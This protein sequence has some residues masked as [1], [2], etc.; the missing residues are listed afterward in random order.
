MR[1]GL[2]IG[3]AFAAAV[4]AGVAHADVSVEKV[5]CLGL[6]GCHRLA[7]GAVEVVVTT[8]VGPRI[9]SYRLTGGENLFWQGSSSGPRNEW[10]SYGG[11]RLWAAP[12]AVPRTYAPDND[13]VAFE[14]EPSGAIRLTAPVEASTGLQKSLRVILDARGPGVTVEH[15]IANRGL[16]PI[17]LAPWALTVFAGGG[18]ALVPQEPP[19]P[20]ADALLPVRAMA[21][22][23]Y[24][25]MTDPR[26]AFGRRYVRVRSLDSVQAPLKIGFG[27][28][29]GWAAYHRGR[30]LF[31]KRFAHEAGARYPDLGS[32]TEVFTAGGILE[33]E[34]LAPLAVLPPG[35]SARHV[36]RWSLFD[37]VTLD[38]SDDA[39]EATLRPLLAATTP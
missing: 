8:D 19:R 3:V 27:N 11:H 32:N 17:E 14:R 13:P 31:V 9:V 36:E 18:V 24:T 39:L 23:A 5:T 26:L 16:W 33:V 1:E 34:T 7:N 25:D 30:T 38:E 21:L 10:R 2:P 20:H 29:Q 28:T 12:E 37:G 15:E 22:W 35:E 6:P 4:V